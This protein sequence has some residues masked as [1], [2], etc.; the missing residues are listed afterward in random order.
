MKISITIIVLLLALSAS[1]QLTTDSLNK[2]THCGPFDGG[3]FKEQRIVQ[4]AIKAKLQN[5]SASGI[6]DTCYLNL[7][8]EAEAN[9]KG[10]VGNWKLFTN[11]FDARGSASPCVVAFCD[12]VLSVLKSVTSSPVEKDV[13]SER[14]KVILYKGTVTVR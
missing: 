14:V 12:K 13:R 7:L 3:A 4:E 2:I 8:I 5:L 9:C 6:G 10:E 11:S 1:A